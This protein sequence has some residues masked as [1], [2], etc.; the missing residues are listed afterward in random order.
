[1]TTTGA[2]STGLDPHVAAALAYLA[3]PFSGATIL[4]AERTSPYV[5]FHAWQAIVGLGS[6]GLLAF[7]FLGSAFLALFV[8]PMAFTVLYRTAAATAVVWLVLWVVCLYQA[9]TGREWRMPLVGGFAA[10]KSLVAS[11]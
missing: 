9:F 1:M 11:R 6:L 2:S 3:G 7:V 8:S 10:R 5:R 4:L